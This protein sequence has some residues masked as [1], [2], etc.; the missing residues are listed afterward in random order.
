MGL[1]YLDGRAW[2][3]VTREERFFCQHL[4]SRILQGG[5]SAFVELLSGR[6]G[7]ALDPSANWEL[8]YEA[9]FYRDLWFLRGRDGPLFSPKRT[10]DLCLLSDETIVV[11]EA[12][13]EQPFDLSQLQCFARDK[14]E[15][16]KE[17]GVDR[18]LLAGL[19]SSRYAPPS[20]VR[21]FFDG[22]FLT[23]REL[24]A[25][26]GHDPILA[27]ADA[28]YCP[29]R[30]WTFGKNSTGGL[31]TGAELIEAHGRGEKFCVGRTG[32]LRGP[33]IMEDIAS[34]NWRNHRY[35]TNRGAVAPPNRNWFW[36]SD[37]AKRIDEGA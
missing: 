23:W 3:E 29:D 14:Q 24:A 5:L 12:K 2:T 7:A 35:E 8:A 26:Y 20:E 31:L 1:R 21:A 30:A 33:K 34:G 16:V 37:F 11:L 18:V 22:P 19:A 25:L 28:L 17:T 32:G 13:A 4:Y 15:L 10:F 6:H 27:R 9:C 36:L